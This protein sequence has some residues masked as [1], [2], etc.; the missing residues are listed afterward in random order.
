M[1]L[2][3][4]YDLETY[5]NMFLATF[6]VHG[7]ETWLEF[8]ISDRKNDIKELREFLATKPP[9]IGFNNLNF[10]YPVLHNTILK[11]NKQW[12][13]QEI[14]S[15]VQIII[16]TKYSAIASWNTKIPQ[17]DL[18]KIWHYDN[19]NKSCS[20]KWL[21]FAMRMDNVE[22]LPYPP[23]TIL[24]FEQMDEVKSYCRNDIKA[25]ETFFNLSKEHIAIRQFYK[26]K[27]GIN[28]INA[29]ETTMAKEIFAKYLSK[30]LNIE[31][32]ELKQLRTFRDSVAIKDVIFDYIKFNDPI[33]NKVLDFYNNSTW[34]DTQKM[35]KNE[36]K[37][38]GIK[39]TI[40]YKNVVREYAEGG[41][42][43]FGKAGIYEADDNYIIVDVDFASFYP[44]L[45]FVNKLHPAHIP[46]Q[47][48]NQIYEGFYKERK[49]YPKSNPINYVLKILLN[50]SYGL[51][52]EIYSFL[53]DP[54]WQLSVVVN[55]QLILTL[56]TEK[57]FD[58]ISEGLIIFE[59]TDGAAYR[60]KKDEYHLLKQA[61][62][63]VE[64]IVN[65]PLEMQLCKKMILSGCNNYINIID[66]DNIKFKGF[67]DMDRDYHKN[68]SKRIVA[69]GAANYFI[70]GIPPEITLK[71][72]LEGNDYPFAKNY[73]IFDYC[74][75]SKMKGDNILYQRVIKGTTITDIKLGKVNRYYVS[76]TGDQLI[77]ILP[78]LE[79]AYV[80]ETDKIKK[81]TPNQMNIFD[82]IEDETLVD[83]KDRE[84]N[85]EA[86]WECTLFNKYV[87]KD[88]YNLSYN[89][90]I[91][92]INKLIN[93]E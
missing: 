55:G 31:I 89:Y 66:D 7:K 71:H 49:N 5:T 92:E 13:A 69:I 44:H 32:S 65:I 60:I 67:Y 17:L 40:N 79:K 72:H 29:S 48:F 51:S 59:N 63:E 42:H 1:A 33:N 77:K 46:E 3:Y 90:Y 9:S 57:I 38:Y 76:K 50:S 78:P 82:I 20:L 80:T 73:G 68:H 21:E 26:Q 22:D 93:F 36:A 91:Q 12:T 84:T 18:Y 53:Y 45:T 41:L 61:C 24:T 8:E 15:E 64:A 16:N 47:V 14:F 4:I 37:K 43:G 54:K 86:G 52:K 23:N 30:E 83:P 27:E 70:N 75:G 34:V 85:I 11:N 88:D 6:K 39:K 35:S 10:D 2:K 25:T 62:K 87:K 81:I 28:L 58:K 19:K 74:I 56:L